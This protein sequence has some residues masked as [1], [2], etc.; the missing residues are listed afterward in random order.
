MPNRWIEFVK[1]WAEKHE[2]TYGCALSQPQLKTDYRKMYPTKK[3]EKENQALEMLQMKGQ[4]KKKKKKKQRPELVIVGDEDKEQA[5]NLMMSGQDQNVAK[6]KPDL[7]IEENEEEE[8]SPL[9]ILSVMPDEKL[10]KLIRSAWKKMVDRQIQGGNKKTLDE[11][12]GIQFLE[13]FI[14][15]KSEKAGREGQPI[16]KFTEEFNPDKLIEN[17]MSELN[18][19]VPRLIRLK[20]GEKLS[21]PFQNFSIGEEVLIGGKGSDKGSKLLGKI[22]NQTETGISVRLDD[23]DESFGIWMGDYIKEYKFKRTFTGNIIRVSNRQIENNDYSMMKLPAG[24]K[25]ISTRRLD[26]NA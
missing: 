1:K 9:Y 22:I 5:E 7:I 12:T 25:Y 13:L 4:D 26:L 20:E 10:K 24:F 17:I 8:V 21:K 3:Q 15:N 6:K 19:N 16:W 18:K 2:L 11:R 23:F 14:K